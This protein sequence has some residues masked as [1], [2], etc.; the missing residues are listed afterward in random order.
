MGQMTCKILKCI[1][2]SEYTEKNDISVAAVRFFA[3]PPK[4]AVIS[5]SNLKPVNMPV[6]NSL[7][8]VIKNLQQHSG[9]FFLYELR[10]GCKK[11]A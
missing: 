11:A 8:N 9:Y 2:F 5:D 7:E 6:S 1:K 10:I 3:Y 4:H